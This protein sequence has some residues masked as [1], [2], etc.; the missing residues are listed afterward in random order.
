MADLLA[1][2]WLLPAPADFRARVR[3]LRSAQGAGEAVRTADLVALAGHGLDL[4]QLGSLGKIVDARRP[5][6]RDEG[7]LRPV[8]LGIAATHTLDL[9]AEALPATGL[10]HGLLVDTVQTDYGQ[11]AQAVLDPASALA[12]ARPDFVLLAL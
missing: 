3:T 4:S 5:S 10:R 2:P 11:L 1:L 7:R 8:L 6:L 12:A 9:V